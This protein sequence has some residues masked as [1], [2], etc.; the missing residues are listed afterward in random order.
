M[1]FF[2]RV[3]HLKC[4]YSRAY[5][6]AAVINLYLC[7]FRQATSQ[8]KTMIYYMKYENFSQSVFKIHLTGNVQFTYI[9]YQI[10]ALRRYNT[11]LT[12][13]FFNNTRTRLWLANI[14]LWLGLGKNN[15]LALH[16][17]AKQTPAYRVKVSDCW[18]HP[19]PLVLFASFFT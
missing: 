5:N 15:T 18:T 9:S 17:Y 16:L 3:T 8:Y 11:E 6:T 19:P 7:R 1:S 13:V 12:F 10:N 14:W 2:L 4:R